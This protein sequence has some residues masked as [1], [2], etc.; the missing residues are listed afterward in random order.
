MGAFAIRGQVDGLGPVLS[1]MKSLKL[2]V[3]N[4]GIRRGV[5]KASRRVAK[6]AKA[7]APVDT[8]TKGLEVKGLYKKSIGS[9]VSV[10]GDRVVG[11]VGPR[12]GFKTQVGTR[13]R[14][15]KKSNAGDPVMQDPAN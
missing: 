8:T 14:K 3:R 10:K 7:L 5:A 11:V 13:K 6:A 9:K 4:R 15:G 2:G 1:A 12:R